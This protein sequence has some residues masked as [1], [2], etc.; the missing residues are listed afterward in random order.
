MGLYF[1]IFT[2]ILRN[3]LLKIGNSFYARIAK[4]FVQ[5]EQL[6][7]TPGPLS[8]GNTIVADKICQGEFFIFGNT[9]QLEDK[10]IWDHSLKNIENNEDLHGFTWLDDLAARGDNAAIEIAQKWIFSWIEKY[11]S[12]SGA[13]WTPNLTGKR[14]IR[15]IHHEEIILHELPEKKNKHLFW[16]YL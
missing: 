3:Y 10:V 9:L 14:L 16:I 8:M 7:S 4:N 2:R 6:I 5:A 1:M 12:G 11:G 13:G 15:L